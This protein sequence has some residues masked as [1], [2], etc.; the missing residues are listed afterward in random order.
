M[1]N[2]LQTVNQQNGEYVD[3]Y[4]ILVQAE[5]KVNNEIMDDTDV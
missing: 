2:N 4:G 3:L 5:N 1:Q